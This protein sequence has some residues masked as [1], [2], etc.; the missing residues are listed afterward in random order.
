MDVKKQTKILIVGGLGYV[1]GR[2]A[3]Y[4]AS[5]DYTD[6][7]LSTTRETYPAWAE[8]YEIGSLNLRSETT[9]R[10]CLQAIQ[11]EILIHLGGMQQAQCQ[12]DPDG[13]AK[14]NE[15]GLDSLLFVAHEAG[16]KRFVYLSTFQVYGDFRGIIT[17]DTP[18]NPRS[19]YAQ[20]KFAGENV[21]RRYQEKGVPAAVLRLAN[22]YGYPMDDQVAGSVWTLAVNAFCRK[23]VQEG[24]LTIKSDQ[25]RDFITMFDAVRGIEH[26]MNLSQEIL[27]DGL[28]NL[29]GDNCVKIKDIAQRVVRIYAEMD[30]D[31]EVSLDGPTEDLDKVFEPFDYRIDKIKQTGF[32]LQGDMDQAIRATLQFCREHMSSSL[33]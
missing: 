19:V 12:D 24:R 2:L 1:G 32:E 20:T 26:V 30:P 13:A 7:A 6:V 8:G 11:P 31:A 18:P 14:V 10:E 16:V 29:G 25:Y 28:F 3:Q 15:E 9:I 5:Q 17:E 33:S 23:V 22:A 27:G 4:L 21:V